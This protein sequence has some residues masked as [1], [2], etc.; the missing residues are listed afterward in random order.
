MCVLL[1]LWL[2]VIYGIFFAQSVDRRIIFYHACFIRHQIIVVIDQ[3]LRDCTRCKNELEN[4]VVKWNIWNSSF[5]IVLTWEYSACNVLF[6]AGGL[7]GGII[8]Y[9][10]WNQLPSV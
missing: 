10:V 7:F 1:L 6:G 2:S 3:E 8:I 5:S 9:F 4:H